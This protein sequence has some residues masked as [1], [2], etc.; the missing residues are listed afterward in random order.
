MRFVGGWPSC[1]SSSSL[2]CEGRLFRDDS[3]GFLRGNGELVTERISWSNRP[4]K[5]TQRAPSWGCINAPEAPLL[6]ARARPLVA[7]RHLGLLMQRGRAEKHSGD[8]ERSGVRGRRR[9]SSPD[10]TCKTACT[11]SAAAGHSSSSPSSSCA[12]GKHHSNQKKG[13]SHHSC[14]SKI[15]R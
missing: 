12:G 1:T 5:G 8:G 11:A 4:K 3:R 2:S 9:E 7:A 13:R 10:S 14:L 15:W 6:A